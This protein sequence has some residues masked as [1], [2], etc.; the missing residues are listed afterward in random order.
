MVPEKIP[1]NLA[2]VHPD[3]VPHIGDVYSGHDLFAHPFFIFG[4]RWYWPPTGPSRLM[5]IAMAIGSFGKVKQRSF[6]V[7]RPD[8]SRRLGRSFRLVAMAY[9]LNT[10]LMK[11]NCR[12]TKRTPMHQDFVRARQRCARWHNH[13]LR[14]AYK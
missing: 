13:F 8:T 12:I 6:L 7:E 11:D 2:D 3:T 5:F 9:E 10:Q 1:S 14:A 4:K